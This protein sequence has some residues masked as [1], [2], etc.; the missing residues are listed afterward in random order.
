M[1]LHKATTMTMDELRSFVQESTWTFAKSMPK[2]PHEYTLRRNAKD[3]VFFER[4]VIYIRQVG[5]QRKW[6]KTCASP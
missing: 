1:T 4:V 6:G 3:E 5:Y 2:T